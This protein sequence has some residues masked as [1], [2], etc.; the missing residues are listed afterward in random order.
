MRDRN[1]RRATDVDVRPP[2]PRL[3]ARGEPRAC[4][5]VIAPAERGEVLPAR[6]PRHPEPLQGAPPPDAPYLPI[7]HAPAGFHRRVGEVHL[8]VSGAMARGGMHTETPP[9]APR[10]C[11]VS[12]GERSL[13]FPSLKWLTSKG[14]ASVRYRYDEPPFNR[15]SRGWTWVWNRV[16]AVHTAM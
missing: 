15:P 9:G 11:F 2:R 5:E 7:D 10:P 4:P 6:L 13:W 1:G 12:G 8:G 3:H 14:A 16:T